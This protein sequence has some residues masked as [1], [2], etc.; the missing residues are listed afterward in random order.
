MQAKELAELH[1][2]RGESF[3]AEYFAEIKID[4]I[5]AAPI[6]L[7]RVDR[8]RSLF[9]QVTNLNLKPRHTPSIRA[10]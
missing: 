3:M 10:V 4:N 6:C 1:K 2:I 7:Y 9:G 8:R 5:P